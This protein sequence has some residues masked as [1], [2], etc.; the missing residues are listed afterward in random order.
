MNS[1]AYSRNR[2]G[3]RTPSRWRGARPSGCA[4]SSS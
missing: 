2:G 1:P 4:S 3:R